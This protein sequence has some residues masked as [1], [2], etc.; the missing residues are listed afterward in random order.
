MKEAAYYEKL[1]D[2]VVRCRLCPHGCVLKPGK[3]GVC[4]ARKNVDGTLFSLNYSYAASVALDP[5]EKK[6]LYH[7]HPGSFILSAGTFGCNL[8]C[9]WCQ[10]WSIA[11]GDDQAA[12]REEGRAALHND[13]Q[14]ASYEDEQVSDP[15]DGKAALHES[16]Q[17]SDS[18]DKRVPGHEEGQGKHEDERDP[19]HEDEND[20]VWNHGSVRLLELTPEGLA[21]LAKKYA[22]RGSIGVAYTYNE[23]AV[24][25]E[26]VLDTAKLV[27]DRGLSNVLVTNGFINEEPLEELLPYVDAMNIDV[28]AFTEDF[29][30]KYCKGSL[31]RVK[32][33]VER[34]AKSCHVEVTTL[35]I[36][37]LNDSPEEIGEL[38]RWL[39]AI[40]RDIVLHLSRF[41]PNYRMLNVVPTPYKTLELA[42]KSALEHLKHV[43]L[44][45][46]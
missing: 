40:D 7:F 36:P 19:D 12:S 25:Y 35:V 24:W 26:F 28:K 23:P 20:Y 46:V 22:G 10:N 45:N 5:I 6:P 13:G 2:G 11:H 1:N 4:R 32:R 9:G 44:G 42:K 8:K 31:E 30:K 21:R 37:G 16:G 15:E 3:T 14:T 43:Y 33:T 29:Y 18:A 41:F 27:K 39:S 34:A 38:A 17:V